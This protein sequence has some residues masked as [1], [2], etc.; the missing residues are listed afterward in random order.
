[1]ALIISL[2]L[3]LPACAQQQVSDP[4]ALPL[5]A[6]GDLAYAGAFRLP[7]ATFGTS[8]LNYSESP[9]V[10]NPASH[11]ILIVGHSHH[12][13]IAEFAVPPLVASTD[14]ADLAMAGDPLQAFAPVL[15]RAGGGNSQNI[16]RIGR[17]AYLEGP[18][19]PELL[20]NTY[21]YYDAPGDNTH[22]TLAVRDAADLANAQVDGFFRFQGGAG[23]TSGWISPI[24]PAWQSLLGG[25]HITGQARGIP[26]ISR[27][28]V[29]PSAFVFDPLAIVSTGAVPDPVA[30]TTLLDF[31]LQHPL[32][33]DLSNSSGDNDLWTHLSRATY[34]L[35][36]PGTRSH[37]TLG[38]SGGH[39]SGVCYKCTQDSGNLCGGYCA[40]DDD[41][42]YQ[43]Y[44]LWDLND[45]MAVMTGE[46]QP[47]EVHPYDYGTFDT[48]FQ[49]S[50]RQLGGGS[51]D[52]ATGLLYLTVQ[53]ADRTQGTYANPPVVVAPGREWPFAKP[54]GVASTSS[55]ASP[56][57]SRPAGSRAYSGHLNRPEPPAGPEPQ[58][59]PS[60]SSMRKSLLLRR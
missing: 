6:I 36:V 4:T 54:S 18:S 32:H 58:T 28:S 31:S 26:I 35:I 39:V 15:D 9:L 16:D 52:P 8:S 7:A 45:L 43:F 44:W 55:P 49:T 59:G 5:L 11:S 33:D 38:Y 1:M 56:Q 41:D 23:R 25:T 13:E 34:G 30:T 3:L 53:R 46:L 20:V 21:E 27:T 14:L 48:P 22:T 60:R 17:L 40:P 24:P 37:L 42:Y 50:Q 57:A 47:H 12:Q 10:Y 51:F 19:G 29:G 2:F